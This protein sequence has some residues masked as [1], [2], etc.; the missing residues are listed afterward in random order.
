MTLQPTFC[1]DCDHVHPDTRKAS[2][3]AGGSA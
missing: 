3:R 2:L 1:E